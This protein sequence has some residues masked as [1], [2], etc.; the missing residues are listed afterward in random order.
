ML[1]DAD[2]MDA[3][4]AARVVDQHPPPFGEDRVVGGVPR[5]SEAFGDAGDGEVL[6]NDRFQRPPQR[7]AREFRSRLGG[8]VRVLAPHVPAA[9]AAVAAD[10]HQQRRGSPPERLMRQL[11]S[12]A[13]AGRALAAAA[14]TPLVVLD[15]AAGQ[16]RT[17]RLQALPDN[18]ETELVEAAERSQVRTGEGSS[19]EHVEVFPVGG[20]GTSIFGRPRPSAHDQRAGRYTLKSEEPLMDAQDVFMPISAN[21]MLALGPDSGTVDLDAAKVAEYNIL[22]TLNAIRWIGCMPDPAVEEQLMGIE[23]L[24]RSAGVS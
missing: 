8:L 16:H 12:H 6:A 21:I 15:D 22:Q 23:K 7:A 24:N 13:V 19:V 20:V 18:D 9:G 5:D 14:A 11:P 4:E 17:L 2:D 1:I 3:V 10:R